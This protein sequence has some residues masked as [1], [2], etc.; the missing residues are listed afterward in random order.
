[1]TEQRNKPLVII[2]GSGHGCVIESCVND[3]RRRFNDYEW[4][5]V[6]FCNDY[7]DEVDGYPVL[8]KLSDIPRLVSEGYYFSWGI[9]LMADNYLTAELFS[10]IEVPDDR[11]A[12][13]VH[14]SA[15]IDS[16]VVLGP[17]VFVM[18]NAYI[19]PRTKIGKCALIKANTNI[20][21]DVICDDLCHVAMGAT[22]VSCSSIGRC[23]DVAVGSTMLAHTSIG[24]YS[25]LG[26]ASLL[27]H[28]IPEGEIWIGNPAR[29]LRDMNRVDNNS[30]D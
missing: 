12:T 30:I 21:H 24:D 20:G 13:V 10:K 1:M 7:D 6:G 9:H 15:F 16:S 17:G 4:N 25:M 27:T 19:A 29:K 26:A 8:G 18:Y 23:A 2:G 14:G 5:V 3:N 11:W 22:I 28:D